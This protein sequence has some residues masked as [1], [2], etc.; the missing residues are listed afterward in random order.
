MFDDRLTNGGYLERKIGAV[1]EGVLVIEGVVMSPIEG[2]YFQRG[3]DWWLWLKRK[4]LLEYD[5][6]RQ[7]FIERQREPRW[8]TYLKKV[9]KGA[10]AYKGTFIFC[11]WVWE[12]TGIWDDVLG[13]ERERL[14]LYV[15]RLPM[16]EQRIINGTKTIAR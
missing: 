3:D 4:P 11:K 14:N 15:E 1:R 12:I 7:M 13:K 10:V 6:K 2:M 16:K 5:N 8:E 9:N